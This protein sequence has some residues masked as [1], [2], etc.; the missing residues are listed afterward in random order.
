MFGRGLGIHPRGCVVLLDINACICMVSYRFHHHTQ[1]EG[2]RSSP[3]FSMLRSTKSS[4]RRPSR[5][6]QS[7]VDCCTYRHL[8]PP[9]NETGAGSPSK[10]LPVLSDAPPCSSSSS[11][12]RVAVVLHESNVDVHRDRSR[13]MKSARTRSSSSVRGHFFL[14]AADI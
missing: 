5:Q 11:S 12:S 7:T 2:R 8:F 1:L 3:L 10:L 13:F 9:E 4:K 14:Y 6:L